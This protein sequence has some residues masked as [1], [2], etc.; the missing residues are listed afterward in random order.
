MHWI[1]LWLCI[2]FAVVCIGLH[3]IDL[4]SCTSLE[5]VCIGLLWLVVVCIAVHWLL[6]CIA[7]TVTFTRS[8]VF[9]LWSCVLTCIL[10]GSACQRQVYDK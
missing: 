8:R 2:L 1:T 7:L 3:C 9:D 5:V 10:F 6:V 4:L